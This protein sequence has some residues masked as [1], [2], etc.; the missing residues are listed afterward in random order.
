[1]DSVIEKTLEYLRL[2]NEHLK[3]NQLHIFGADRLILENEAAM[4]AI[5]MLVKQEEEDMDVESRR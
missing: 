3:T 5:K 1:M 2:R 4:D